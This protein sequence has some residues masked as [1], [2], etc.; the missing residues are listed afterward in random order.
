MSTVEQNP[1]PALGTAYEL[2][3]VNQSGHAVTAMVYAVPQ[4][5]C[6]SLVW[7]SA[8]LAAGASAGFSWSA[9][10]NFVRGTLAA[11]PG[12]CVPFTAQQVVDA[13]PGQS[14]QI[15]LEPAAG[16]GTQFTGQQPGPPGTLLINEAG[17]LP[18]D[19]TQA[20]GVGI[21]GYPLFVTTLS[22]GAR[23]TY[24]LTPQLWLA[25]GTF[26][27]GQIMSQMGVEV[28]TPLTYPPGVTSITALFTGAEWILNT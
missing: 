19:E 14:N 18:A 12:P 11:P 16:G 28:H 3:V 9:T 24:G 6:L 4:Q 22:P 13:I 23:P 10:P 20:V 7:R 17:T 1:A 21:G 26:E 25:T 27:Q 15:T 2:Q 8:Q 5:Q